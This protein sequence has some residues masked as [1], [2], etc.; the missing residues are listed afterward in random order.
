MM[1]LFVQGGVFMYPLLAIAAVVLGLALWA[2]FRVPATAGPDPLLETGIDAT[3][4][5]GGWALLVGLLGTF[6]GIYLAAGAIQR[7]GEVSASLAWG[8]IQVALITTLFGLTIFIVA[9][10]IWFGLRT[11]YRRVS[12][13]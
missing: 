13:A 3:L 10:L 8:G 2:S 5:W 7:A 1:E 12:L 9:A 11:W 6:V 4:F